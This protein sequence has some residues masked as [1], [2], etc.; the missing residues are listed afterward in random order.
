M[1]PKKL[2]LIR[3]LQI[4]HEHSDYNHPL[5]QEDII[6]KLDREYGIE[7]ERKAI[8]R[9]IN[10]LIEM[11]DK[12]SMSQDNGG[13]IIITSEKRRG[14]YI[15][16]RM[17]EDSELHML[18][19]GVL[20]SKYITAKHSKDLINKLCLLSNKHF[21]SHVKN[22]YS[23]N[24]WSK[25]DN[26]DLFLNIELIDEAIERKKN[27]RFNY[28]RYEIDKKLHS[29]KIHTVSPYQLI[30]NNQRYYLMASDEKWH[31]MSYYRLDRIKNMEIIEDSTLVDLRDIEEYENGIDYKDLAT[32]RPYMYTDKAE[33]VTFITKFYMLNQIIDWFGTNFEVEKIDEKQIKIKLKVSLDAMEYWAMQYGKFVEIISPSSLRERVINNLKVTL[34]KYEK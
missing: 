16:K 31:N 3:I 5:T 33:E 25:T 26:K 13:E 9:H 30:L 11:F 1:E 29:N 19:D 21:R 28:N 17:F 4:L 8:G 2:A 18:I 34:N 7:V 32:S 15:E 22:V 14:T 20:S 10:D 6:D 27:I 12:D 24:D 23:I